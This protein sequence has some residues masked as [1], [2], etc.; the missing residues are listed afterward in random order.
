[1]QKIHGESMSRIKHLLIPLVL[2]VVVKIIFIF[3]A[4]NSLE[5]KAQDT[6]FRVRGTIN[7]GDEVVIVAIDNDS[8]S[9][10]DRSWP[11]PREYHA[12]L[13]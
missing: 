4:I 5:N 8:F 11:F 12:K 2:L 7:H 6:L 1:M 3:P 9:A 10:I 13:I